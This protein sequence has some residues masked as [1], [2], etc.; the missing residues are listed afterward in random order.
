MAN[1]SPFSNIKNGFFQTLGGVPVAAAL[2]ALGTFLWGLAQMSFWA[3]PAA[4]IAFVSVWLAIEFVLDSPR[5]RH[6]VDWIRDKMGLP[7]L[8]RQQ[9]SL[10][11]QTSIAEPDRPTA[12]DHLC[13]LWLYEQQ[14]PRLNQE[15]ELAEKASVEIEDLFSLAM[16]ADLSEEQKSRL[17]NK[18]FEFTQALVACD[19]THRIC[20]REDK[21][22]S[23]T[24]PYYPSQIPI[25]GLS[26]L[27]G[28]LRYEF[29]QYHDRLNSM[30]QN[31]GLLRE[32]FRF[33]ISYSQDAISK[34]AHRAIDRMR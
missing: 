14:F 28:D 30:R 27:P 31:I 11:S 9:V 32:S 19:A 20:F 26:D 33:A 24:S 13:A 16:M 18:L 12:A 3:I 6:L 17:E 22:V 4:A 25:A 8:Q 7:K 15:I 1:D 29:R 34:T 23:L 2:A 5:G 21:N 10:V